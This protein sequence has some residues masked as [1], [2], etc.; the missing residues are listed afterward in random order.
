MRVRAHTERVVCARAEV[1][2]YACMHRD[3]ELRV[4]VR[5]EIRVC[6]CVCAQSE[7]CASCAE[8]ERVARACVL[9]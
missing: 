9:T 3:A 6:V 1:E 4:R 7:L 2:I 8:T 5:R